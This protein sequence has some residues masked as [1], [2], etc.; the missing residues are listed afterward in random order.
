MLYLDRSR[1]FVPLNMLEKAALEA[2][3]GLLDTDR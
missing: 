1:T 3:G 2:V